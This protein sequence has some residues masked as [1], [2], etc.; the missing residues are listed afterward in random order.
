MIL[1][2]KILQFCI[3][4]IVYVNIDIQ[5]INVTFLENIIFIL[6]KY[7]NYKNHYDKLI[8]KAQHRILPE[9]VYSERHHI[10]PK[11]LGGDNNKTNIVRLLPK[12]HYI[13]H[14]L[15]FNLYPNNKSLAYSFWMMSNGSKKNKRNYRVSGKIYEEIR[16][17]ISSIMKERTPF[18]QGKKHTEESKQKNRDAHI[19][20]PGTWIGKRHS[21]ESKQKMSKKAIGKKISLETRKK[22]SMSKIGVKF[23]DSHKKNMSISNMG[24][25]NNYK[26]FLE[27]TGLPHAKSKPILQ[28][29]LNNEL[30]R[31]WTNT[32]KAAAEL[33]LSYKAIYACLA[34]KSKTS[35]GFIWK[36]KNK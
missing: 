31:E 27:R 30:I 34:E 32:R 8:E 19:G 25:N 12:E 22:M 20:K 16:N 2:K 13:A 33:G 28:Y 35:Q 18:F 5:N 11:C 15:L 26:R 14:L 17:K 9:N 24:D 1:L 6:K 21:D 3:F 29:N 36:F 7:M 23:S 4:Q 10:I